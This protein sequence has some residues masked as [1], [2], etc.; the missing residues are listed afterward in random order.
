MSTPE[1][2]ELERLRRIEAAA[3]R[4]YHDLLER[5]RMNAVIER[6]PDDILV[7]VGAS[8][9]IELSDALGHPG[10][11]SCMTT[12]NATRQALKG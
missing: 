2:T 11:E 9:W 1:K 4:V 8:V 6:H 7:S 3:I 12:P 5:G 10:A